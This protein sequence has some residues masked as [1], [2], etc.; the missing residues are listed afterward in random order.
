MKFFCTIRTF[1]W[2]TEQLKFYIIIQIIEY[3]LVVIASLYDTKHF[4]WTCNDDF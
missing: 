1:P 2:G 4:H 3:V